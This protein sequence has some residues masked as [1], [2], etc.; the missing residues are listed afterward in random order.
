MFWFVF[1]SEPHVYK[2]LKKRSNLEP[3]MTTEHNKY[4]K[5]E[6]FEAELVKT[7]SFKA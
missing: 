6:Y 5:S 7:I 4:E 2:G 1:L 3:S